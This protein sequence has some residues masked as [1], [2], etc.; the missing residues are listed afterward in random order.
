MVNDVKKV[1]ENRNKKC[2]IESD[3]NLEMPKVSQ[4]LLSFRIS[5]FKPEW[6]LC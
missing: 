3:T 4:E 2:E 6:K 5:N 1:E